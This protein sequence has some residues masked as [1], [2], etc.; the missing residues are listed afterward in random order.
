VDGQTGGAY[1]K[2]Q[3]MSMEPMAPLDAMA[4]ELARLPLDLI[5]AVNTRAVLATKRTGTG[6]PVVFAQVSEPIAIELVVSLARPGRN[7]TGL[8]TIKLK[9]KR[10][11]HS[12]RRSRSYS[13]RSP[14]QS[15][16]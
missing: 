15:G 11:E 1:K 9:S 16:L 2:V 6:L 8:T 7:F 3:G 13:R 10:L 12:R 14:G 4:A 5:F